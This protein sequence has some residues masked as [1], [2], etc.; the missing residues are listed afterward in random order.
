MSRVLWVAPFHAPDVGGV[1]RLGTSLLPR[2]HA[3]GHTFEVLCALGPVSRAG[4]ETHTSEELD[5]VPVHRA[6]FSEALGARQPARVLELLRWVGEIERAFDPDLVHLHDVST[7]WWFHHAAHALG[8]RPTILTLHTSVDTDDV[9][10]PWLDTALPT[11]DWLTAV[12]DAAL[13]EAVDDLPVAAPRSSVLPNG[14]ELGPEPAPPPPG[15]PLVLCPARYVPQKNL[16]GA[17]EAFGFVRKRHPDARLALVGGGR[18]HDA[19]REQIDVAGLEDAIDLVGA[20][21]LDEMP[22]WFARAS[23]VA[24][25]SHYE[26]LPLAALEAMAAGR[27]L[28]ASTAAGFDAIVAEGRTGL[29]AP[30]DD[31]VAF[32]EAISSL[33]DDPARAAAMGAAG[34]ALVARSFSLESCAAGYADLYERLGA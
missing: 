11:V 5:G 14:V 16:A 12:T 15:P 3:A 4:R 27:P 17:V 33:L 26:G 13:A 30:S 25:P 29:R 9:R 18:L 28:V 34:R 20:R 21:P 8:R 7:T 1:E 19:L 23:V 22:S 2:L 10:R 24:M 6:G 32:A 31:A